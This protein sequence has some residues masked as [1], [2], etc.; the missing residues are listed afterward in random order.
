M[1]PQVDTFKLVWRVWERTLV[2]EYVFYFRTDEKPKLF[3]SFSERQSHYFDP[4]NNNYFIQGI[5]LPEV[6]GRVEDHYRGDKVCIVY[7]DCM[8]IC[9]EC[10]HVN[11]VDESPYPEWRKWRKIDE[12]AMW[13]DIDS[14]LGNPEFIHQRC[15]RSR[16]CDEDANFMIKR[17]K[18][19][20]FPEPMVSRIPISQSVY[21]ISAD[22]YIK[23]GIAQ[24]VQSR[25]SSLQTSSPFPLTLLK[26]WTPLNPKLAERRMHERFSEYR[27]SGEWFKLPSDAL[28]SLLK[29]DDLESLLT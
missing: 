12:S 20:Y 19:W 16:R 21:V 24:N 6:G 7:M 9:P 5:P 8:A 10:G 27:C 3:H 2:H 11:D 17:A 23:I 22:Q 15:T 29:T 4:I 14:K 25:L 13:R 28:E 18:E 26:T 1:R